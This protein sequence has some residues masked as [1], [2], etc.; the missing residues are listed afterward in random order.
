MK[1]KN[2][3]QKTDLKSLAVITS[4]VLISFTASTQDFQHS[5]TE[6]ETTKEMALA[7]I[8]TRN[9]SNHTASAVA[10]PADFNS[11]ETYSET[12]S[13]SKMEL[14]EWMTKENLFNVEENPTKKKIIKTATFV[15]EETEDSKLEF[16]AWMFNPKIW[17][18][19]K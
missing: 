10:E 2:N 8:N 6:N 16:E 12:E 11:T 15:F 9:V 7:V 13:E 14:E 17:S 4:F 18:I 19:R 1:T 3:N 5:I